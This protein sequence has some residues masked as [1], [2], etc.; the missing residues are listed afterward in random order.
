MTP[1]M[2]IRSPSEYEDPFWDSDEYRM[3]DLDDWLLANAEDKN[4][5]VIGEITFDSGTGMLSWT[6]LKLINPRQTGVI[7]VTAGSM[8]LSDGFFAYVV[9]PRPYQSATLVMS[10]A[11][12]PLADEAIVPLAYR[13]GSSVYGTGRNTY[14]ASEITLERN[15]T[16]T[17]VLNVQQV[18]DRIWGT[19]SLTGFGI[20]ENGNGTVTIDPGEAVFHSGKTQQAKMVSATVPGGTTGSGG[21][22]A[23]A[24][25][26]INYIYIEYNAGSPQVNVTQDPLVS[27]DFDIEPIFV[28]F[29]DGN[30]THYVDLRFGGLDY[31][32]KAVTRETWIYQYHHQPGGTQLQEKGT[33]NISV[34]AGRFFIFNLPIEHVAIDT[35]GAGV[36]TYMY[37]DGGG[38]WT[39]VA[40][41]TQID[42]VNYD[43]GTGTLQALGNNKY[44]VHW[45][46]ITL[47]TP[48]EIM[49]L[50]GQG[51]YAN[52]AEA[53]AA[54]IPS[55]LPPVVAPL[56]V[57]TFIGKVIIEKSAS[58][59]ADI[60]SPFVEVLGSVV[61]TDHNS[62][63]GL[64]GGQVSQYYH[65]TL[66]QHGELTGAGDTSLHYHSADRARANHTGTQ[67]VATITAGNHKMFYS[68]GSGQIV[69]LANVIA[70]MYIKS[71]GVSS[72]P[73]WSDFETDVSNTSDVANNTAARHAKTHA[74]T[75][76][77]NHSTGANKVYYSDSAPQPVE[78]ALGANGTYLKSNGTTSAPSFSNF[79]TDVSANTDVTA[80]TS[81]RHTHGNYSLLE[82]Y[83]Q[84]EADIES[85]V[86]K[87]HTRLHEM[88]STADHAAG[89]WK[90]FYTDT[91]GVV[92]LALG[93]S[94]KVLKSNGPSAAPSWEDESGGGGGGN[95]FRFNA[96]EL[97]LPLSSDWAV[98]AN[99]GGAVDS[100]N[101]A[102]NVVRF[103]DTTVEGI[104][105]TIPIPAGVT[106]MALRFK[107]RAETAPAGVRTVGLGIYN[108][109]L[110]NNA[111]VQ[112]W[113][114]IDNLA[115]LS[116]P[117]NEY[118]QY[119]SDSITLATLGATA[120]ELTQFEIVRQDPQAGT[121]LTGDWAL[122]QLE[123]EFS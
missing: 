82:T 24:D 38:G 30:N 43:P 88:T 116:F 51:E 27:D 75:D 123:V 115:D 122:L 28:V 84:S 16:P 101:S 108:R 40:S 31:Q 25:D 47:N 86:L 104:G 5:T 73:I 1:K 10:A 18:I 78:L 26:Q 11:A 92:E 44:G 77:A 109:G 62:L 55:I 39:K 70:G 37:R 72:A 120:G 99:A 76:A 29:R 12:P 81:A 34:S 60:Q 71:Q 118:W 41:S 95:L 7:T 63:G 89:S 94:G 119:D 110:P 98:N 83:T 121:E 50:Y 17:E 113:S 105:F 48:A 67:S 106:S 111:A 52:L 32:R 53:Q 117:T 64:Q 107:S 21:M 90:T 14:S 85:A 8:A 58:V 97:D 65:L 20:T 68:N 54:E 100:N 46:Y 13:S 56:G 9:V 66:A 23:L 112:S 74:I 80:N 91:E 102:L 59:F 4:L 114:S 69:E 6:E 49:V 96:D 61:P 35:S 87:K 15:G 33:R 2:G 79:D 3:T 93:A 42:N 57:S 36:F 22:P 45:V 103:D 19:S